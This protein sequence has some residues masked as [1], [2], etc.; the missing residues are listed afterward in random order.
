MLPY[1]FREELDALL[2]ASSADPAFRDDVLAY[3]EGHS[4]TRVELHRPSPR[5]KVLRLLAHLLHAEPRLRIAR[6]QVD[7]WSGCSD[8]RGGI[9][10]HAAD[11]RRSWRF[12]WDCR[13]AAEEQGW[14]TAWGTPDQSRAADELGW[15][16]FARWDPASVDDPSASAVEQD[17]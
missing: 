10:V 15:R 13:W 6:V 12:R 16:C 4:A 5:I 8:F 7:A 11:G 14:F 9:D 1:H 2:A 3:A 17:A